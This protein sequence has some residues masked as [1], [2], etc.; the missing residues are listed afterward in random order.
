MTSTQSEKFIRGLQRAWLAE[1]SSL[2]IYGDLAR[3]EKNPTRRNVLLK[4]A[5]SEQQHADRWANRLKELSSP[6]PPAQESIRQRLWRWILVKTGTDNALKQIENAEDKDEEQY[7]N[8]LELAISPADGKAIQTVREDEQGHS[9]LMHKTWVST[10]SVGSPQNRLDLILHRESWHKHGG[11]WIGQAIYGA[12]DGL[13]SVFGIVSG[14]AGATAGGPA[15]LVAGLAG[16]L[17]SALSMGSGAYLASKA[18][19]EVNQAEIDRE[20]RELETHPEEEMEEL[21]LFYQLKGVPEGEANTLAM[22]LVAQPEQALRAL[23]SEELGFTDQALSNP[24]IEAVSATLSTALGAFIPIIP[25]FFTRGYPAIIASFAISTLAHFL[26]G[27]SKTIVTGLSP[28]K[29][30]MEMTLV[31]LGEA[32]TTY[33]V[34]LLISPYVK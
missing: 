26:I 27:A 1:Q 16:M 17:A 9:R 4:L 19:R 33:F 28:W 21:S 11:G 22:R 32:L 24:W 29:S 12:N 10:E 6:L 2:R 31:G 20:R 5:E 3:H 13:G 7:G 14:V 15:V 34:G 18:E 25:F 30:G 23:T 8:L